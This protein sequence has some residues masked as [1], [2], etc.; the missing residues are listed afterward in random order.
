MYYDQT[1]VLAMIERKWNLPVLTLRDA[2]VN[3]FTDFIDIY[4]L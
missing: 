1:S 4:R 2:D 3:E